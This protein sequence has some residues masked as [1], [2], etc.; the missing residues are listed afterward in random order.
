ML[1]YLGTGP[2][3]YAAHPIPILSRSSWEFQIVVAGRIAMVTP[4]GPTN[5]RSRHL[6]LSAPQH[7]H[8][9]TGES[10]KTAEVAVF[11]FL[12]VPEHLSRKISHRGCLDLALQKSQ[13]LR[14]R[15]LSSILSRYWKQPGP[16]MLLRNEHALLE[17]SLIILESSGSS[18][19]KADDTGS[20]RVQKAMEWFSSHM[21]SNPSLS[22][23]AQAAGS[24]PSH[25]RRH[26]H[27][28]MQ[29]SPKKIFDQLRFQ[30]ATQ[31]MTDSEVK[32]SIVSA[33]CGFGSQS[34]FSRA[35][36]AKFGI[37]PEQWKG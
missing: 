2:R 28:I 3:E 34:A 36:K 12:S 21:E 13:I 1:C 17:L 30:R 31:L 15:E 22:E 19:G 24:S 16:E 5:L 32:L 14:V 4:D 25:L 37:P 9:W 23:V 18:S 26:F 7:A 11:Q 29:A 20:R 10:G 33:A 8:G 6:W 35:F 27:E